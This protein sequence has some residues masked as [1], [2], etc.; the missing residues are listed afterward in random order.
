MVPLSQQRARCAT[1]VTLGAEAAGSSRRQLLA[2]VGSAAA[3]LAAGPAQ[4]KVPAGFNA[5]KDTTKG[6]A[7]I[8]PVGWQARGVPDSLRWQM[9]RL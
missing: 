4:A 1:A 2:L 9:T 7:F 8:Y 3:V 6:Y 5:L